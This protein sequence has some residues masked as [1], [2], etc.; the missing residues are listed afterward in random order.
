MPEGKTSP[1]RRPL[2]SRQVHQ[3][4]FFTEALNESTHLDMMLIP[5]GTF[6]MGQTAAEKA[7]LIRLMGDEF[8]QK[9]L[10][11]ELPR[12]SVSVPLFFMGKYPVTQAQWRAVAAY[13]LVDQKLELKPDP[14]NFKGDNHPVEQV[15]WQD[16]QE[17]C[18]RLSVMTGRTYR[19]PSEAE[20]EYACRAGTT[21]PFYFG[22]TLSDELANYCAQDREI[23]GTSYKGT[24]GR[25][26]L[27]QYR[28]ATTEVGKFP[29]N[30]F[31]LYDMHGNVWEWCEDDWHSNYE[32]APGDGS[33]WLEQDRSNTYKLVRGGS[34]GNVPFN[35][36]SASR[37]NFDAIC[38][39]V[40]FRVVCEPPRI[41]LNT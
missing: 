41:L 12:H 26:V 28:E 30:P 39:N 24:Y 20:W 33:A 11:S 22:E 21:T 8:Y 36:R 19:L 15:S 34:W 18:Q 16:A 35:C 37:I 4:Q 10:I 23:D 25:G 9:Y 1:E 17:F 38:Y 40:G 7:E 5:G 27:G 14:S 13:Q 32:S 2:I 29:A 6:E 3:G 31:G